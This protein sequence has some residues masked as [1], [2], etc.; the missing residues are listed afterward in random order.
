MEGLNI[1]KV[2]WETITTTYNEFSI[3]NRGSI[4]VYPGTHKTLTDLKE[5]GYKLTLCTSKPS[6]RTD[7]MLTTLGLRDF[8]EYISSAPENEL[9]KAFYRGKPAPDSLLECCIR[10]A[11][12][13]S[14]TIYIGDT[15]NDMQAAKRAGCNFI[16]AHWGI[17]QPVLLEETVWINRDWR[18]VF[19]PD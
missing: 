7:L 16:Y 10:V 12:D 6:N 17:D 19:T 14:D 15:V 18:L 5:K 8:F 3:A 9:E 11:N 1:D 2:Y 4:D 13:P